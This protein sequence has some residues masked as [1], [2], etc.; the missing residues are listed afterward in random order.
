MTIRKGLGKGMGSGYRNILMAHDKRVHRD[1]GLGR[2][3]PQRMPQ[4]MGGKRRVVKEYDVFNY[5][6]LP[7]DVKQKA[8]ERY[9][10]INVDDANWY[11]YEE[12]M[13]LNEKEMKK[14][15][16]DKIFDDGKG[17]NFDL[18]RGMYIQFPNL[19]VVDEEGFRKFLGLSKS[20]WEKVKDTYIFENIRE[21][22]TQLNFNEDSVGWGITNSEIEKLRIAEEKFS[23]KV[24]EAWKDLRDT[25]EDLTSKEQ[26]EETFRAN[27]YE[28][29]SD[30]KIH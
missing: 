23:N 22:N 25:Y 17:L 7:E 4:M 30:G 2:K 1:A 26:I 28:F 20:L 9:A 5:D 14:Y 12:K 24:H 13:G 11:D 18:D 6:E 29:T 19:R 8:L 21:Q 3:Q 15:G 10:D 27:E 16:T